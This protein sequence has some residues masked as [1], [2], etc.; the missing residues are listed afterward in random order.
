MIIFILEDLYYEEWEP[1]WKIDKLWLNFRAT[2]KI[3]IKI[4]SQLFKWQY[5][6]VFTRELL[7]HFTINQCILLKKKSHSRNKST[8]K[9]NMKQR[10]TYFLYAW[11]FLQ[12]SKLQKKSTST[13]LRYFCFVWNMEFWKLFRNVFIWL[14]P[15]Q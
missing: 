6:V 4:L 14:V 13:S 3:K 11:V 7:C 15:I 5:M 12:S 10:C 8:N 1:L 9:L 2:L